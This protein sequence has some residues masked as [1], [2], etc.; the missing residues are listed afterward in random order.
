MTLEELQTKRAALVSLRASGVL[1]YADQNGERVRY[2]SL[3]AMGRAIAA[4]DN[5]IAALSGPRRNPITFRA[6][7]GV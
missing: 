6:S 1:E 7:K 5:E 3:D 2:A 4:L